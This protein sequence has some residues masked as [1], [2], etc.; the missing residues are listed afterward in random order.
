MYICICTCICICISHRASFAALWDCIMNMCKDHCRSL[1]CR[2]HRYPPVRPK[3]TNKRRGK[4]SSLVYRSLTGE[5][6]N[7]SAGS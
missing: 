7:L 2:R 3:S 4:R 1:E 5:M 6:N